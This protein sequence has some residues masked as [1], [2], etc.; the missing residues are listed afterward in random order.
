MLSY[1]DIDP[2]ALALGPIKIHWYGITSVVGIVAAWLLLRWRTDKNP[3]LKW[4][5]EQVDDM[6]FYVTLGV[7]IGGRLGSVLFYNLPYYLD[8]PVDIFKI[9]QG[10]MSF[11]GGLIGALLAMVWFARKTNSGFFNVIDFIAPVVPV[12]LG[13][14]RIGNFINGEL[15]GAPSALP[16]AMIFPDPRAGGIARHPSQLYEALLEGLLLFIIL[17]LYSSKPRPMMAVSGLFLLGYGVFRFSVEFVRVPDAHIGYLAFG[18][19]TMGQVLSFP[20]IILGFVSMVWAY[21]KENVG[22]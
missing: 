18:W 9:N 8:H 19:V 2:I 11:H 16:W 3:S 13:C 17:W 15:W 7:I 1:P 10:G 6:V 4:S 20:M 12:G 14:G 21:R 22:R 5:S